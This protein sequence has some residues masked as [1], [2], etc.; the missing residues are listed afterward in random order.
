MYTGMLA[1]FEA[2]GCHVK[3]YRLDEALNFYGSVFE[4]A[5]KG[6]LIWEEKGRPNIAGFCSL[7][8]IS[9]IAYEQPDLV[10][11]VSGHNLH[12]VVP[13]VARRLGIPSVVYC[14]ESPYF[15]EKEH[16]FASAYDLILT[17]EKLSVEGFRSACPS[18]IV[19]YLPHAY[20]PK[21]HTPGPKEEGYNP[22]VFFVGSG[23]S[24]RKQ[25]FDAVDWSDL[26][27]VRKGFMWTPEEDAG[28]LNLE[29]VLPNEEAVRYYRSA[30]INLNH[31][32]TTT[33]YG[34]GKHI[35]H[36]EAVSLGPRAY[37]IAAC[38][39]FQ[40]CDD[41]RPE[42]REVF[43]DTMPTYRAHSSLSLESQIR[44][45]HQRPG[46]REALATAQREAILPHTWAARAKTI[47]E[48]AGD[49]K[50]Q[51]RAA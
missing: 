35:S 33:I 47:L 15:G 42:L 17:N 39:G 1:G 49:L 44:Y 13:L 5:F 36:L 46:E 19:R 28:A 18:R 29:N 6:G 41:S 20:N 40:L 22:D 26:S 31:H 25:L 34:S 32:R 7:K 12:H 8:A 45:Y 3:T 38:G 10:V 51:R 30:G 4:A 27:F 24:E 21:T 23:F 14:T 16:A 43:G 37:E 48:W 2:N 11:A 9:E 50:Q